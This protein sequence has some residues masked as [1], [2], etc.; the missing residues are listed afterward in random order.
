[1][2]AGYRSVMAT[3]LL[4][5]LVP[6]L[7]GDSRYLLS[8]AIQMLVFAAYAVALNIVFGGTGQLFLCLGALAGLSAYTTV[9]VAD[10]GGVPLPV[11]ITLGVVLTASLGGLLSWVAARRHLDGIFLG[12]V[13]LAFSLV[14]LNLLLGGRGLTGGETG[15]VLETGRTTWLPDR[16]PAYYLFLGLLSVF[17]VVHRGLDR[18]RIGWA[19]RALRDD[20]RAA[21]ITG[22]DVV[23]TK[24]IA[25]VVGAAMLGVTGAVSALHEG[26]MSPTTWA[27]AHVDVR[28]LV[29]LAVGGIGT[30]LGPVVGAVALMVVDEL[31][32]PL[33]QLRLTVYGI[34]LIAVF[35]GV[36]DGVVPRVASGYA[37]LRE[38]V[39]TRLVR[40]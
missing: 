40:R 29:I 36:R 9:I 7:V 38:R 39:R 14:F 31:L 19:F 15:L 35:L 11:A 22:V 12:I 25:G 17:L 16:V 34:V 24:V 21:E 20:E 33:G 5:A 18:S 32:R 1:M 28:V 26:F 30:L 3:T 23:R 27:F 37:N 13:T 6:A 8:L 4:L 10:R 2:I